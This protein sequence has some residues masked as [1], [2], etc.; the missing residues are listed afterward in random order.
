MTLETRRPY[1]RII[2][3]K[4]IESRTYVDP[5]SPS[6]PGYSERHRRK[7]SEVMP[8]IVRVDIGCEGD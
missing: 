5:N 3:P 4:R 6:S 2:P 1:A 7:V 8:G